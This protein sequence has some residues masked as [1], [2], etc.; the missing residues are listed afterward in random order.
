MMIT[1]ANIITW[2]GA[3]IMINYKLFCD[4]INV[5]SDIMNIIVAII[6]LKK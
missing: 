2:K 1:A 6:L 3:G 5:L 4:F